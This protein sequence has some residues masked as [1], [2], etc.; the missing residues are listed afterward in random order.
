MLLTSPEGKCGNYGFGGEHHEGSGDAVEE[1]LPQTLVS[2]SAVDVM[3][4]TGFLGETL[5]VFVENV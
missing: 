4:N 5:G 1:L 3:Y 2:A